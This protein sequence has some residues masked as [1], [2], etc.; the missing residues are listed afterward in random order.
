MWEVGVGVIG[1]GEGVQVMEGGCE[2]ESLYTY[3]H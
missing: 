2:E 3:P 1:E